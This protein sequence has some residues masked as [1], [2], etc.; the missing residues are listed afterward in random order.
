MNTGAT[1]FNPSASKVNIAGT[2]PTLRNTFV[3][4]IFL[5]PVLLRSTP[6]PLVKRSPNGMD[7]MRNAEGTNINNNKFVFII[8]YFLLLTFYFLF[9]S[10]YSAISILCQNRIKYCTPDISPNIMAIQR[11]RIPIA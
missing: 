8:S 5:L 9:L 11:R 10:S 2:F 4:P 6:D 3:A 7:P 1:P